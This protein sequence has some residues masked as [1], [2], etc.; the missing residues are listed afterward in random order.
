M[1]QNI[2]SKIR[3]LIKALEL[4]GEIYLFTK[5]QQYSSK[6][7]KTCNLNKLSQVLPIDEYYKKHPEKK[8]KKSDEREHVKVP[9]SSSFKEVNILLTLADI[10]KAGEVNGR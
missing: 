1:R 10:Y 8:R 4:R 6:T 9:I 5:E 7:Q 3:K 2:G